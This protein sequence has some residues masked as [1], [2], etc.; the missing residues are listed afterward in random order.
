MN[1]LAQSG[2]WARLGALA[3]ATILSTALTAS[4]VLQRQSRVPACSA[5]LTI[6]ARLDATLRRAIE[7]AYADQDFDLA[8]SLERI[9]VLRTSRTDSD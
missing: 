5:E 1:S 7:Q 8:D 2:A 4:V 6:E 3:F 9:L